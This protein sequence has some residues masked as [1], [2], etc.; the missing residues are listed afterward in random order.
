MDH[1]L[2]AEIKATYGSEAV[3]REELQVW[4]ADK[5]V[6]LGE[7][8]DRKKANRF[9]TYL[10][11]MGGEVSAQI[12]NEVAAGGGGRNLRRAREGLEDAGKQE[13]ATAEG[14][15]GNGSTGPGPAAQQPE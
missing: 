10:E 4:V 5:V 12:R 9:R 1:D 2:L 3:A 11:V 6:Q 7:A 14:E 8:G 13:Q 15:G